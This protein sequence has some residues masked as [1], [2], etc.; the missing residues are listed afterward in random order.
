MEDS[1]PVLNRR[2]RPVQDRAM[3]TL[4]SRILLAQLVATV[5]A[6]AVGTVIT[7]VRLVYG[8]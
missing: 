4:F 5:F 1:K 6:L 2:S 8:F 7:R 3:K